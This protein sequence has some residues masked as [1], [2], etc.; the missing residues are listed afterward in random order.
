MAERPRTLE[1]SQVLAGDRHLAAWWTRVWAYLLDGVIAGLPGFVFISVCHQGSTGRLIGYVLSA[2]LPVAYG[3]ILIAVYGRTFG[4]RLLHIRATHQTGRD[5]TH[6]EAWTRALVA[7]VLYQLVGFVLLI[8]QWSEP[9]SWSVHRHSIVDVL[10][11]L[12]FVLYLGMFM[13]LWD[14][15]NQTLQDKAVGSIVVAF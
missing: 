2:T 15:N 1:S 4:M 13:P 8:I 7:F 12:L 14:A 6:A 5:L 10:H 11:V 9:A 3:A